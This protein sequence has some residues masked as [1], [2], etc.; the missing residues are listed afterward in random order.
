MNTSVNGE[1]IG[2]VFE[3]TT[4]G[5]AYLVLFSDGTSD[6]GLIEWSTMKTMLEALHG[7]H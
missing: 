2:I 3:A 4:D 5:L 1:Y 7:E 6:A